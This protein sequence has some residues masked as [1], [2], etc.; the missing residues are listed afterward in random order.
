MEQLGLHYLLLGQ[1]EILFGQTQEQLVLPHF[2]KVTY[3]S[4][5]ST[6]A[7]R[8]QEVHGK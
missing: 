8:A 4:R 3:E 7:L 1:L 5:L 6:Q 2:C